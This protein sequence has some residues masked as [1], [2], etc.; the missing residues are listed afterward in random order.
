MISD[1][2]FEIQIEFSL[3]T[4]SNADWI[5]NLNPDSNPNSNPHFEQF[6]IRQTA[7]AGG[8]GRRWRAMTMATMMKLP[9]LEMVVVAG[10]HYKGAKKSS[11]RTFK[12]FSCAKL[13]PPPN[14]NKITAKFEEEEEE[15]EEEK[16][17]KK[18]KRGNLKFII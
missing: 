16:E 18:K 2:I 1:L 9:K 3:V 12:P 17:K 13:P 4:D 14:P 15:E 7:G 5:P 6:F 8:A 11:K 10:R